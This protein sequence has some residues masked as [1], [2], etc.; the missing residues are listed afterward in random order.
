MFGIGF[1]ELILIMVVALIVL[2]PKRLPEAARAIG[3]FFKEFK[4]VTEE[5]KSSISTDISQIVNE[6]KED[7][8]KQHQIASKSTTKEEKEHKDQFEEEFEKELKKEEYQP[9]REKISFNKKVEPKEKTGE[10]LNAEHKS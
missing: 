6:E 5:V 10:Q 8:H 1:Q 3:K 9:K 7:H 2:G 4:S